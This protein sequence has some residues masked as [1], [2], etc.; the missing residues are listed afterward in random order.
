MCIVFRRDDLFDFILRSKL[1]K[2][3]FLSFTHIRRIAFIDKFLMNYLR[4]D[5]LRSQNYMLGKKDEQIVLM[6]KRFREAIVEIDT[7]QASALVFYLSN[8]QSDKYNDAIKIIQAYLGKVDKVESLIKNNVG[9]AIHLY[10]LLEIESIN[11]LF[12]PIGEYRISVKKLK[13]V[14]ELYGIRS[15]ITTEQWEMMDHRTQTYIESRQTGRIP[16]TRMSQQSFPSVY[17]R[18]Q[19]S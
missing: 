5:G 8:I 14:F 15:W 18:A 12:Q 16:E 13:S 1:T 4:D 11:N 9:T 7:Y 3:I 19:H 2:S 10:Q 6:N 17:S